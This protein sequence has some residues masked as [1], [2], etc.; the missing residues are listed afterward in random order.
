[1]ATI[2]EKI[3]QMTPHLTN[4]QMAIGKYICEHIYDAALMNAAKIAKEVGVSEAT[5][6]RFVYALSLIHICFR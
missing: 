1:M 5:L 3:M 4:K 2:N 6:T